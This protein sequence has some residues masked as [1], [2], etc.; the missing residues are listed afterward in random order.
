MQKYFYFY[1]RQKSFSTYFKYSRIPVT[2]MMNHIILNKRNT[3]IFAFILLLLILLVVA[4]RG[5]AVMTRIYNGICRL[6]G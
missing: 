4:A 2:F 1:A 6:L 5:F 3:Y